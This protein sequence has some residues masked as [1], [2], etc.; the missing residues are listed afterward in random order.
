M[1]GAPR[2][3]RRYPTVSEI[4]DEFEMPSSARSVYQFDKLEVGQSF[5]VSPSF[6]QRM[7]VAA[8][9]FKASRPGWAYKTR[10]WRN[11]KTQELEVRLWRTA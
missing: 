10:T 5:A 11:P 7:Q 4:S 2:L 1:P 6:G 9:M 8:S 3:K